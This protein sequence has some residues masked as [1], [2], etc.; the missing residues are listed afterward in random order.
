MNALQILL[1]SI[2]ILL[3][4][5]GALQFLIFP[6]NKTNK[7]LGVVILMVALGIFQAMYLMYPSSDRINIV[8]LLPLNIVFA[9]YFLALCY[10]EALSQKRLFPGLY[11]RSVKYI[12]VLE[13]ALHLL[14]LGVFL[15]MGEYSRPMLDFLFNIRGIIYVLFLFSSFIGMRYVL[16]NIEEVCV[17]EELGRQI[18]TGIKFIMITIV[19]VAV[20]ACVSILIPYFIERVNRIVFYIPQILIGVLA[21]CW[22]GYNIILNQITSKTAVDEYQDLCNNSNPIYIN[23]IS[24]IEEEKLYRNPNLRISDVADK[25][26]IS[27][28]YLSRIINET[29]NVGFNEIVNNYRVDEVISLIKNGDY[30]N[31][32]LFSLAQQAGFSSKSTFQSAFKKVTGKTPSE[33][34][35]ES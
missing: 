1:Y 19:F 35:K 10:L 16:A 17:N 15:F 18:Y 5:T 20:C 21:F 26:S 9:P 7:F 34:K 32:T 11:V 14:P 31:R 25:L 30:K 23:M 22:G 2:F 12:A 4:L 29:C 3:L 6:R 13:V 27:P 8:L 28:N 24:I 33:Y